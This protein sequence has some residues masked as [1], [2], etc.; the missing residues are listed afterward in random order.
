M[1]TCQNCGSE[2]EPHTYNQ[3]Y[4]SYQCMLTARDTRKRERRQAERAERQAAEAHR[5]A[6]LDLP[7]VARQ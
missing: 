4:C 6:G 1:T 2:F 7:D 5:D 3:K